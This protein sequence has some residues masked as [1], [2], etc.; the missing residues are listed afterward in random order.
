VGLNVPSGAAAG[1]AFVARFDG[2]HWAEATVPEEELIDHNFSDVA[3]HPPGLPA[4]AWITSSTERAVI[5]DGTSWKLGEDSTADLLAVD[6]RGD[7]MWATGRDGKVLRHAASGWV[8]DL[9]ARP[10]TV[11]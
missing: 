1:F 6:V 2:Q 8:V 4:G 7:K 3:V 5:F 9:P 11:P 10:A